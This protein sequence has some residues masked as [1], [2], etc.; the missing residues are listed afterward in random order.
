MTTLGLFGLIA[1]TC[2]SKGIHFCHMPS[3]SSGSQDRLWAI[4]V[5]N[6]R[7]NLLYESFLNIPVFI[8]THGH[9]TMVT[10]RA[11][12]NTMHILQYPPLHIYMG[13]DITGP[14]L[15]RVK[16]AEGIFVP[17]FR[18]TGSLP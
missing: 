13:C 14:T 18:G 15:V 8:L 10:E 12:F 16:S 17:T 4:N 9:V 11:C 2:T 5:Q 6:S 3:N 7:L 1:G